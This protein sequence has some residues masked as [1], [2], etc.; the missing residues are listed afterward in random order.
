MAGDQGAAEGGGRVSVEN[1]I[2]A[3][4]APFGDPVEKSLLYAAARDLPP[5]YYTFSCS[6]FGA[7]FGDDEPGCERWLVNVHF[8]APLKGNYTQQVKETKKALFRAGF[9]W[10]SM[11]DAGDKEGQHIVFECEIAEE[12]ELDGE[13]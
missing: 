12:V 9:T 6:S 8:F 5:R 1:R 7:D 3:A 10:P 4:L 11:V 13:I 2:K